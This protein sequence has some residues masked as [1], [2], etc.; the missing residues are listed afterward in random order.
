MA[1]AR[2]AAS[3]WRRGFLKVGWAAMQLSFK[4]FSQSTFR[5]NALGLKIFA[6]GVIKF[7]ILYPA[8]RFI[9]PHVRHVI[10]SWLP[11]KK[12]VATPA[13]D[14]LRSLGLK[15]KFSEVYERN[16]FG[17]SESR[18]GE[19][20]DL[21]QTAIVRREIPRLLQELGIKTFV[22]APCGDWYWMKEVDLPVEHYIGLDIV[23]A[24]VAKNQREFGSSKIAFQSMNLAEG[25]LPKADL[26]FSRDCLV[27]LS[28]ADALKIIANFKRSGA[29]YLLTTTF[30][31]RGRNEDL[32][33][34]FGRPLNKRLPPFSF[35]EPIR[36]IN[37]GCTAGNNLFADKCLG[38]WLLQDIDLPAST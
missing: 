25:N 5:A 8:R 15:E 23:E 37:E 4:N 7:H 19:G 27:H 22:D 16:I 32:G 2:I 34:G 18:S 1:Y 11:A 13:P 31:D 6:E 3:M 24:L 14:S 28:F 21:S 33:D 36:L 35:P 12:N 10:R 17:G 30:T 29:K 9:P 26:I 20:S 38:L